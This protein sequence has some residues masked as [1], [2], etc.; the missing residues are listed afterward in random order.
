MALSSN[1]IEV[2]DA[3]RVF[4]LT[5]IGLIHFSQE[6]FAGEAFGYTNRISALDRALGTTI[7]YL[8]FGK[9]FTIFSFLF[10]LSFSLQ[11][12]SPA[13]YALRLAVLF[14]IGI[15]HHAFF[16]GDILTIYAIAGLLLLWARRWPTKWVLWTGCALAFN[17]P[18]QLQ[19]I[20]THI[21]PPTPADLAAEAALMQQI[22]G[23]FRAQLEVV[24][25][26]S[27]LEVWQFHLGPA[28]AGKAVFQ[29]LSGRFFMT[30]GLFL[31]GLAG[32]RLQLFR[33]PASFW[34]GVFWRTLPIVILSTGL[35]WVWNPT[36]FGNARE[37]P[38][39]IGVVAFDVHQLSLSLLYLAGFSWAYLTRPQPALARLGRMGLTIY[40]LQTLTGVL[41]FYGFAGGQLGAWGLGGSLLWGM[42]G[43]TLI[44]LFCRRWM[45]SHN[46]GPVELL[47][48]RLSYPSGAV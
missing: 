35:T 20:S 32:G 17:L 39:L 3:L 44:L 47:W 2:V 14:A 37:W 48:R 21:W 41:F 30:A 5:G 29:V 46:Q 15:V 36:F 8:A 33:Q 34:R 23:L 6:F 7:D 1:R 43:W 19:R 22:E 13:R 25:H 42:L 28:V 4:A 9:F 26:G 16:P 40:L 10:G 45:A 18:F 24:R 31:L 11:S 38:T 27:L 12:L